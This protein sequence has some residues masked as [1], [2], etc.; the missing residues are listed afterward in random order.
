[1]TPA[2]QCNH[3]AEPI[4]WVT[5]QAGKNMPV[6]AAPDP[7]RGNVIKLGHQWGVLGPRPATAARGRGVELYLHHAV[8]CPYAAR[9]Q[10]AKVSGRRR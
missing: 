4:R 10:G 8:T 6:N 7:D 1:M 2:D 9:W 3:C 5:T